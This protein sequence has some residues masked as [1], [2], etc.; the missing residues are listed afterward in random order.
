MGVLRIGSARRREVSSA[1]RALAVGWLILACDGGAQRFEAEGVVEDVRV[2]EGQVLIAH[3]DIP[4]LM[5]AMTMSF[6]VPD[7][8]LV[9]SLEPGHV[10][11]FVLEFDGRSYRVVEATV[12]A[13]V[14]PREGYAQFGNKLLRAEPAPAFALTDQDGRPLSLADL[15]G[16]AVLLDFIFTQ[17]PG[18]CPILT[19]LHVDVQ[20]AVPQDARSR[21]HFVSVSLDPANDDPPALRA[22]ASDRGA[23]LSNWSFL[24]GEVPV[25]DAVLA[26]YQIGKSRGPDG[27]IDHVVA[28]FLI[29]GEGRIVRRYLGLEHTPEELVRDLLAAAP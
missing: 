17:C 16:R 1:V 15:R 27:E 28:T 4:G 12:R 9:E 2:S 20:K 29:D 14:E 21:V 26:D 13:Q 23:D 6:D 7:R 8:A 5:P 11:D 22:Y 3:E 18:P 25:I 19:G 24:T 10:I